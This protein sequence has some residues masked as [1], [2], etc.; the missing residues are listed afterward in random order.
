MSSVSS[1]I[2]QR[3]ANDLFR[4]YV[5]NHYQKNN[6]NQTLRAFVAKGGYYGINLND[7]DERQRFVANYT[8]NVEKS[9]F[10]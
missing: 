1:E 8:F 6:G 10:S 2:Y 4:Q 3:K 5:S 7:L 9:D